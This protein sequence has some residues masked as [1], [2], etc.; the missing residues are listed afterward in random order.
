M[1][2]KKFKWKT[3]WGMTS[4]VTPNV[5]V[6]QFGDGYEQRLKNGLNH[7]SEKFNVLVRLHRKRDEEEINR[8]MDFLL[9]HVGWKSFSWIPPKRDG[10]ITVVCDTYSTA[11][12]GVYVDFNLTF[13][14][15]FDKQSEQSNN[16]TSSGQCVIPDDPPDLVAILNQKLEQLNE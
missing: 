1:T 5:T 2:L 4:E 3:Q 12:S 6:T 15:V 14:Q 9:E 11:E 16:S 7:I 10:D 13:R 8:L